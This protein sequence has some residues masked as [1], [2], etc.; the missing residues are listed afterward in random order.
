MSSMNENGE[1]KTDLLSLL[2]RPELP[3]MQKELPVCRYKVKRLSELCG[4]DV[5]FTLRGLP[6]GK[7]QKLTEGD[8]GDLNIHILLAG[9]VEPDFKA[10]QLRERFGGATPAETVKAMLLPGEIEDLSRAVEKLCGYRGLTIE[11]VKN[12]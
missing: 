3:N 8:T 6:Y 12:A 5:V 1:K 9:C 4:T 7:V 2:L 11:E 10:A